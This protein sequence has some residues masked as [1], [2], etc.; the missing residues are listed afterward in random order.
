MKNFMKQK[1]SGSKINIRMKS[2]LVKTTAGL[3]GLGMIGFGGVVA[4]QNDGAAELKETKP[5]IPLTQTILDLSGSM[6]QRSGSKTRNEIFASAASNLVGGWRGAGDVGM[7]TFGRRSKSSCTDVEELLPPGRYGSG[8]VDDLLSDLN[9][10]GRSPLAEAVQLAGQSAVGHHG[11]KNM[12]LLVD[13]GDNCGGDICAAAEEALDTLGD[14]K[15]HVLGFQLDQTDQKQLSCLGNLTGGV[16]HNSA[17]NEEFAKAHEALASQI[18]LDIN[19]ERKSRIQA[20][21]QV[22]KLS[23]E[24]LKAKAER[25]SLLARLKTIE[26]SANKAAA[27]VKERSQQIDALNK[28]QAKLEAM[29]G[30]R[31]KELTQA[32]SKIEEQLALVNNKN[33][34][35]EQ[36]V[37]DRNNALSAQKATAAEMKQTKSSLKALRQKQDK[38]V[39]SLNQA[40]ADKTSMEKKRV[41]L[42]NE[43]DV[44]SKL[45]ASKEEAL[46]KMRSLFNDNSKANKE[47]L[48]ERAVEIGKISEALRSAETELAS[49]KADIGNVER[50]VAS[51]EAKLNQANSNLS[52]LKKKSQELQ[53]KL[54]ERTRVTSE[55]TAAAKKA[56][57]LANIADRTLTGL[58]GEKT[59]LLAQAAELKN[60]LTASNKTTADLKAELGKS[61]SDRDSW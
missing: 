28:T 36:A 52:D 51:R 21:A 56:R 13:G 46:I 4:Q 61:I 42:E 1:F 45:A 34:L 41:G 16:F 48:K 60:K 54:V 43:I 7:L 24:I 30:G 29:L 11:P 35:L 58:K 18:E 44:L 25:E 9:P 19:P 38:S 27:E 26:I 32:K 20:E 59:R 5:E 10:R 22:A 47:L 50:Q 8:E 33:R 15:I 12:I 49:A 23:A 2:R 14:V 6:W 17:S 55:A 3:L 39:A 31:E 40:K 53:A 57:E 37:A